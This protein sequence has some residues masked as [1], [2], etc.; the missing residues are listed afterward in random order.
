MRERASIRCSP[1]LCCR[2]QNWKNVGVGGQQC[3]PRAGFAKRLFCGANF[4]R[5][6][7][8]SGDTASFFG[9]G[10]HPLI[11]GAANAAALVLIRDDHEAEEAAPGG[12]AC[13]HGIDA[14]EHAV[15]GEGHV[16]VFG[17]LDDGEHALGGRDLRG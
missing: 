14:G 9:G 13:A 1:R 17:E 3:P 15:E 11:E 5:R 4:E 10:E 12:Q 2:G 6:R 16:L 7:E 8:V